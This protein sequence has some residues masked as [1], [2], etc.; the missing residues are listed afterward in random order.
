MKWINESQLALRAVTTSHDLLAKKPNPVISPGKESFRDITTELDRQIEENISLVLTESGYPII[1]EESVD[2]EKA[3]DALNFPCWIVDPI[4][5]TANFVSKIPFYGIS[6]ALCVEQ[7]FVVGAVIVPSPEE[8]FFTYSNYGSY[9]NGVILKNKHDSKLSS[10]LVSMTFSGVK[11]DIEF[12]RRQFE[13]FETLNDSSLGCLRLGSASVS[14]CYVAAGRLHAACGIHN[15][16]WDVAGS[17]AIAKQAGCKVIFS[18]V[19]NSTRVNYI[20]GIPTV[21]DE[22]SEIMHCKGLLTFNEN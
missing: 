9:L 3:L 15:Q 22:I 18:R 1:G 14:I 2:L 10:S 6:V 21:V 8:L 11:G 7:E 5:G 20:V 16:I 4:D 17:L 13:L 12:R 19:P